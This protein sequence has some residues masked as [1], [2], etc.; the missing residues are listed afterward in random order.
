MVSSTPVGRFIKAL[1][2]ET[3]AACGAGAINAAVDNYN[4]LDV[5]QI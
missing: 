5:V 4:T 1:G 3:A 2:G